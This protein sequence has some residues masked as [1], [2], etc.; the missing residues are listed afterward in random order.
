MVWCL[1][2][3]A[4][5]NVQTIFTAGQC[6]RGFCLVF[7]RQGIHGVT[8]DIGWVADDY[9][10]VA[11]IEFVEQIAMNQLNLLIHVIFGDIALCNSQSIGRQV[12]RI[13]ISVGE[14]IRQ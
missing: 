9:I 14:C 8:I 13:D 5:N 7:G 1:L 2:Q 12:N 4:S 3:N 6:Q 11:A 10:V